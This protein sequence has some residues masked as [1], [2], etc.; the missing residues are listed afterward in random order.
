M[1]GGR[2]SRQVLARGQYDV[3]LIGLQMPLM[4]SYRPV[5]K[6]R[7]GRADKPLQMTQLVAGIEWLRSD[8]QA[9]GQQQATADVK[10]GGLS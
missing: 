4:G 9:A 2:S 5:S 6:H 7:H 8:V 3:I 1:V 10:P